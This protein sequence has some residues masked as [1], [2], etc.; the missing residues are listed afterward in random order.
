MNS[1]I[2]LW[3]KS[4]LNCQISKTN[5]HTKSPIGK[6]P[7]PKGRFE[8][9]HIDLVG[10]ITP[11]GGCT[12]IL[13]VIERFTRWTEAY[14]LSN[15]SAQTVA[16][17]L[18][19]HYFS[20]F[21]IPHTVTHDQGTQFESSLFLEFSKILGFH[22]IHT[23]T[24]HPQSNGML[25]RYHRTLK[26]ALTARGNTNRWK[27]EL[28]LILLGLRTALKD[29][30]QCSS[31]E[32]VYGQPLRLPGEFF[33]H[34]H[35]IVDTFPIL[36]NL[37][38]IFANLRPSSIRRHGKEKIFVSPELQNSKYVFVRME[39]RTSLSPAYEGPY[40]VTKKFTK[41]FIILQGKTMQD[42]FQE[43]TLYIRNRV[44]LTKV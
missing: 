26:A 8:H 17:T 37:R 21:G 29:D 25:E 33:L 24:Y 11:S 44:A 34:S 12:Y 13:T 2:H 42:Q 40:K 39:K 23:T 4:C 20:R 35:E 41:T 38:E 22:K 19:I 1:D 5:K 32:L 16:K 31:A 10:P 27:D 14:P 9:I 28:P 15:I 18:L 6:F 7:I 30:L 3:T 36:S 43:S